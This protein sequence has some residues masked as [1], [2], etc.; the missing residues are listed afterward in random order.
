MV[1]FYVGN[2]NSRHFFT[3]GFFC[4]VIYV[5][6]FSMRIFCVGLTREGFFYKI[7][8]TSLGGNEELPIE[9][10]LSNATIH[11]YSDYEVYSN[12]PS[13]NLLIVQQVLPSVA[14]AASAALYATQHP[15]ISR[16]PCLPLHKIIIPGRKKNVSSILQGYC[17][18]IE[19][20]FIL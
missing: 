1:C 10:I 18:N 16:I 11:C 13:I 6:D 12:Q 3:Q 5:E 20:T 4:V 8:K 15:R 17:K 7:A 2:L 9:L 14:S 19:G